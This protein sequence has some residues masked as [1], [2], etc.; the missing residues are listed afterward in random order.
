MKN[1]EMEKKIAAAVEHASPNGFDDVLRDARSGAAEVVFTETPKRRSGWVRALSCAAALVLVLAAVFGVYLYR[2]DYAVASTVALEVNPSLEIRVNSRETVLEVIPKNDDAKA[3]IGDMDFKGSKLDVTVNALVGSMLR[4]GYLSDLANSILVTVDSKDSQGAA[5]QDKLTREINDLFA[6]GGF[7]GAVLS[8]TVRDDSALAA[9]AEEYGITLGKAQLIAEI[10]AKDSR[11]TFESLSGLTINDLN[12]IRNSGGV[13]VE[14]TADPAEKIVTVGSASDAGYIGKDAARRAALEAAGVTEAEVLDGV[15]IGMDWEDGVMVYEVEFNAGSWGYECE[16]NA[17]D[18]RVLQCERD[19]PHQVTVVNGTGHHDEDE[20]HGTVQTAALSEAEAY[21]AAFADAGVSEADVTGKTIRYEWDDGRAVYEIEF[22]TE[23]A[24]YDY[25][26]DGDTGAVVKGEK[27][28]LTPRS[29]E[30]DALAALIGEAE[31]KA[32]ALR[33]AGVPDGTDA[34]VKL[35]RDDGR[36]VYEVKFT[37]GGSAYDYEIDAMSGAI[38][39]SEKELLQ[40]QQAGSA[41]GNESAAG[42]TLEQAKAIAFQHAGLSE[43]AVSVVKAEKDTDDGKTVYEIEFR[44][45]SDEYEYKIDAATG[46]V[47]KSEKEG[48][49]GTSSGNTAQTGGAGVTLEQ[50]KA[51]ALKHAGF[52]ESAVSGMKAKQDRDDGRTVYEIEFRSGGD[53]YEY[54]IDALTGA[55]LK[56]ERDRD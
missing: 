34:V 42:V 55:I 15:W 29:G 23:T 51:I 44:T 50:A 24:V 14:E 40:G 6:T 4:H 17:T 1:R 7:S 43:T 20:H 26:I 9:L 12:L 18:G 19:E 56:S 22:R 35:D 53:E 52:A 2:T 49:K 10:I 8:Q 54:E 39:K 13:P 31:A 25:E 16:V 33:H 27:E 37:S 48:L 46:A 47:L 36:Q 21:A 41:D 5:L 11:Y 45:E 3:V 32:A 30:S 28:Q 38:L